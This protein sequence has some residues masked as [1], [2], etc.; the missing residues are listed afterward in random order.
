LKVLKDRNEH[1]TYFDI[2]GGFV[3]VLNNKVTVL[4]EGA[5]PVE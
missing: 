4:V 2:Q 3:E 1:V 5:K